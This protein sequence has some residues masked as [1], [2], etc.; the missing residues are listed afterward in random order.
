[1]N[2]GYVGIG[3][4]PVYTA[5]FK[6]VREGK[7]KVV[8]CG[9]GKDTVEVTVTPPDS[10]LYDATA[11]MDV[12][13]EGWESFMGF[14]YSS[15]VYSG[16]YYMDHYGFISGWWDLKYDETA[17]IWLPVEGGDYIVYFDPVSKRPAE[18]ITEIEDKKYL[19]M[20]GS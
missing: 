17:K 19:F 6:D 1:M 7:I 5:K 14:A 13:Q 15:I 3:A 16:R 4:F 9:A 12:I 20:R 8:R 18:D 2:F 11:T 10:D